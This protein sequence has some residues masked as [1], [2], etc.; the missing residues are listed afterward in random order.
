MDKESGKLLSRPLA[1]VKDIYPYG[2]HLQPLPGK[3]GS[4][5]FG[6]NF[7]HE[8]VYSSFF[9]GDVSP[10]SADKMSKL[11]VTCERMG[12]NYL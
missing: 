3:Q 9:C 10:S 5:E 12:T 4:R 7:Q 1:N 8:L 2:A 6:G 11:L